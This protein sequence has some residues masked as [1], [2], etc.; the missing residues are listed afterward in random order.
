MEIPAGGR[1]TATAFS[2]Q[3]AGSHTPQAQNSNR[4][5]HKTTSGSEKY[6]EDS[7]NCSYNIA[8]FLETLERME[9]PM[10]SVFEIG[11]KIAI[12]RKMKNLSQ[13][14]LAESMAISPQAVGKWER[15]E[16]M[17]D[18]L[19][20]GRLAEVLGTDL[21]YFASFEES[22]S[23]RADES[24]PPIRQA[25]TFLKPDWDMSSGS[26]V[27]A[28]FSGIYGLAEKFGSSNIAGCRFVGSELIGLKLKSNNILHCDFTRADLSGSVF[29]G[30]NFEYDLFI[31]S[32]LQKSEFLRCTIKEGSFSEA[33]LLNTVFRKTYITKT[34][35]CQAQLHGASFLSTQLADVRLGGDIN[36]CSFDNCDFH[37]VEFV[38]ATIR[39]TFFKYGKF[40]QTSFS[41]CMVDKLSYAFLKACKADLSG[42]ELWEDAEGR[43]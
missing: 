42:V 13:A 30:S 8:M 43:S 11:E 16:S 34:D 22:R 5:Y 12:A 9:Q 28:D 2:S 10:L 27:D 38:G 18:I 32:T 36:G 33:A 19:T 6:L 15:G 29:T 17:P 1:R 41:G 35:F 14:Q 39:N 20:F 7:A 25:D 23:A 37:R 21:N 24:A 31:G 40:R 4:L 3:I 26:W